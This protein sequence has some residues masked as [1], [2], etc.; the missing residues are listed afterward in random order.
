MTLDIHE[1]GA[2]NREWVARGFVRSMDEQFGAPTNLNVSRAIVERV[3]EFFSFLERSLAKRNVRFF[4]YIII[5]SPDD[6]VRHSTTS[7]NDGRQSLAILNSFSFILEGRNGR[8]FHDDLERRTKGQLAAIDAFV[9]YVSD[10]A[11]QIKKL[12]ETE[13]SN[14]IVTKEPVVLRMDY[15]YE[16]AQ[17]NIPVRLLSS[18]NDSTV[19]LRYAPRPKPL[20]SIERPAAYVIRSSESA[21]IEVLDRHQIKYRSLETNEQFPVE[22]YEVVKVDTGSLEGKRT[23]LPSV[24]KKTDLRNFARG[25]VYIPLEQLHSTMLAITLEPESM[26]GLI[27][28]DEYAS[29][30]TVGKEYPVYRVL[31]KQ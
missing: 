11:S 16:G 15:V 14:L 31:I 8:S 29:L 3:P 10:H 6:T 12:V 7:I 1:F 9:Q 30:R 28:Y 4:D 23:Y 19:A 25:D 5:D 18:G 13:R 22:S 21:L 2:F 26:W 17:I 24:N 20:Y 27:Q